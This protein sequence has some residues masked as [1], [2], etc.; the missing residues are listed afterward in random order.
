MAQEETLA[1][2]LGGNKKLIQFLE[3]L[4]PEIAAP[5]NSILPWRS[6]S[7]QEVRKVDKGAFQFKREDPVASSRDSVKIGMVSALPHSIIKNYPYLVSI[8]F[9][10][11]AEV[12]IANLTQQITDSVT[13]E[14]W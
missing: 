1:H 9:D 14:F 6:E 8:T 4:Y 2:L 10:L 5:L 13:R 12:G 7:Y 11:I 3:D